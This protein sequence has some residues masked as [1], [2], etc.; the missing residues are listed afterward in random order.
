M[1]AYASNASSLC[2]LDLDCGRCDRGRKLSSSCRHHHGHRHDHVSSSNN[3]NRDP[4]LSS[5][6]IVGHESSSIIVFIISTVII[7][8]VIAINFIMYRYVIN[9]Y[10]GHALPHPRIFSKAPMVC[11]WY[12]F[13]GCCSS[14]HPCL[15]I[16]YVLKGRFDHLDCFKPKKI[17]IAD[18]KSSSKQGESPIEG[19][20]ELILPNWSMKSY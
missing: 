20:Y 1:T 13:L 15:K 7:V 16:E 8:V 17:Q 3:N 18:G 6:S 10:F 19:L 4:S 11:S 9:I 2:S 12:L 14:R 5:S